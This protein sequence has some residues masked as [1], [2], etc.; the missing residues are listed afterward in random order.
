[1]IDMNKILGGFLLVM[2]LAFI[3]F[4]GTVAYGFWN[5]VISIFVSVVILLLVLL[6]VKLLTD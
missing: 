4:A 1:M 6:G 2:V 3:V 5:M